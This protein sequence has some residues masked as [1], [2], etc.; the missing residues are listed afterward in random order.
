MD[1]IQQL[2]FCRFIAAVSIVIYHYGDKTSIYQVGFLKKIFEN[3]NVAVSFFYVL[4]G[5]VIYYTY[6]HYNS[7]N[8]VLFFKK[9][10]KRIYPAYFLALLLTLLIKSFYWNEFL[11]SLMMIQT[12]VPGKS[13]ILNNPGWSLSNEMVFYFTFPLIL[14]FFQNTKVFKY[15]MVVVSL[16][17]FLSQIIYLIYLVKESNYYMYLPI[18]HFNS[19]LIGILTAVFFKNRKIQIKYSILSKLIVLVLICTSFFVFNN[20]MLHNGLLAPLFGLLI[21]LIAVSKDKMTILFSGKTFQFLGEISYSIYIFQFP[22]WLFWSDYRISKYLFIDKGI[23]EDFKFSIRFFILI[24]L[25]IIVFYAIELP[26]KKYKKSEANFK[27]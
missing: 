26:L 3:A 18:L 22:V 23:S 21:Y 4:S 15:K 2:T 14:P 6:Q 1:K 27:I 16:I 13:L 19:F 25:S 12:W 7:V 9:R 10:L 8:L 11:L 17:W 20:K 5:F 24:L